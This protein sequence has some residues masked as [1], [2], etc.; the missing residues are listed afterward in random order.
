MTKFLFVRHGVTTWIEERKLHGVSDIPLSDYGKRQA[1]LT[2][3]ILKNLKVDRLYSSPLIRAMQTAEPI[4]EVSGVE[5][6][7]DVNLMEMDFG[8]LEGKRDWWPT[9]RGNEFLVLLYLISRLLSGRVSGERFSKFKRRIID[10]WEKIADDN[11][12]GTVV[13]VAHSGVL[14]IIFTHIFG[15]NPIYNKKFSFATGSISE[16]ERDEKGEFH[17][18]KVN[19][20]DHLPAEIDL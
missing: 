6:E 2:A 14:R 19:R 17:L 18:I 12:S 5:I 10:A 7:K 15:G 9:F 4:S 11:P 1:K 8:Y 16:I 13:V 20:S 3:D